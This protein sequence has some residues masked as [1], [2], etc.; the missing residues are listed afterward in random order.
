[1]RT[2]QEMMNLILNTAKGDNRIRAV[3]MNGSRANP[4]APKDMFQDYDIVYIV[5]SIESFMADHNWIDVFGKRIVLQMP[6]TMRRPIGDGRFTYLMLFE[7]KNRIDLNLLP[8]EKHKE[9]LENDSES[10]LLLDKDG[11]ITPFP[12]ASDKDYYIKTPVKLEYESCCNNFW[13][14]TQNVAKGIWRDELPYAMSMLTSEVKAELDY[15]IQ[16][17]IGIENVFTVSA[18]KLGKYYKHFLSSHQYEMYTKVYSDSDYTHVWDSLFSACDLFKETAL[19]V[20]QNFGFVYPV[21]DDEK[22]TAYLKEVRRLEH[23]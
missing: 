9:L 2:E 21:E 7:D 19:S 18:G 12:P 22:M 17:Y 1:M 3:I 4:N 16:W 6:E 13:W 8:I 23:L 11:I 14:C 5:K 15:M 10:I 20:G